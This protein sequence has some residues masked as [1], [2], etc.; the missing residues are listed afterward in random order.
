[1]STRLGT[2][3]AS[4]SH[5]AFPLLN[6][7]AQYRPSGRNGGKGRGGGVQHHTRLWTFDAAPTNLDI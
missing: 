6:L 1:M 3:R 4:L 5:E 7:R 2:N